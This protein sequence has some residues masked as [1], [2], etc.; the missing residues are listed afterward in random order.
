M[1]SSEEIRGNLAAAALLIRSGQA[2]SRRTLAD[3]MRMSPTTAGFYVDHLIRSGHLCESGLE[4]GKMGRP[5]RSLS[6]VAEAGWF[7]GIEFNAERIQIASVDFS[8]QLITSQ[9]YPLLADATAAQVMSRIATLI[10]AMD[11]KTPGPLL[12]IGVGAPGVVDPLRGLGLEYAFLTG[13]K[14]VPI[15]SRLATRFKVPVT[16]ENNLRTIALAERWFGGGRQLEDYVILGPRSGFGIAIMNQGRLLRGSHHAAGEI[17]RWPW[18]PGQPGGEVHDALTAPAVWRRL[19]GASPRTRQPADL[20]TALQVFS[21]ETGPVWQQIIT[22]YACIIGQLHLLLD[23]QA[24]FLHGPLTALGSRFCQDISAATVRLMPALRSIPPQILPS[25]LG[26][27]AGAL[28]A[29]S[30]AMEKWKPDAE[31]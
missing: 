27:E 2:A 16:L 11:R 25:S 22:D 14:N 12:G 26:D 21:S 19:S 30:L 20:H 7:A 6:L 3:L 13:W 10:T 5:K 17:G 24:Y 28:G 9:S 18:S 23:A 4:Q 31:K 15:S 29:S 8:G 1:R